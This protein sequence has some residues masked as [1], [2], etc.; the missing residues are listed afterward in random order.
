VLHCEI[1]ESNLTGLDTKKIQLQRP[2]QISTP[3]GIAPSYQH[4]NHIVFIAPTRVF[5]GRYD[6]ANVSI[7]EMHNL[8]RGPELVLGQS[9]FKRGIRILRSPSLRVEVIGGKTPHSRHIRVAYAGPRRHKQT[10][11]QKFL[12]RRL[13]CEEWLESRPRAI[14]T[15]AS[16][17]QSRPE[18]KQVVLHKPMPIFLDK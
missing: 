7:R 18:I 2:G 15:A 14:R 5:S 17:A 12:S 9:V 1:V 4:I 11:R 13:P 3:D 10:E 8:S 16:A 6:R